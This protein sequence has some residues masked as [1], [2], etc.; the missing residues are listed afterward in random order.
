[1]TKKKVWMSFC[2]VMILLLTFTVLSIRIEKM[3]RIDVETI[4]AEVNEETDT[5]K[6]PKSCYQ[7][8]EFKSAIFYVEEKEGLFGKELVA[9]RKEMPPDV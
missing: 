4:T 1:M 8:D 6:L 9:N 7:F 3:M 5:A 2:I